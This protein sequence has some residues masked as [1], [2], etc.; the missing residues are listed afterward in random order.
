L[1][2]SG[3]SSSISNSDSF[4][5]L[6]EIW[7]EQ[8]VTGGQSMLIIFNLSDYQ[9]V[10]RGPPV[11]RDGPQAVSEEKLLQK[12]HQTLNEWKIHPYM[13]VLKLTSLVNLQ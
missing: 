12:L 3:R 5:A 4:P 8:H 9:H 1:D 10:V 11:V 2:V 13:F 6:L 7:Y